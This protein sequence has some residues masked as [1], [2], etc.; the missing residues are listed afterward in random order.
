ME[1][2]GIQKLTLLDFP[3]KTA[4]T[5]FTGGCNM[6]CPFCHNAVLVTDINSDEVIKDE[7]I[8]KFLELRKGLLDGVCITGG[9]PLLH[10]GLFG[11]IKKVK[12]IGFLVKLDTNGTFP[13]RLAELISA[14]LVD[15]VAMDIK[16]CKEKYAKT[17]GISDFDITPVEK[18]INLLKNSGIDFEFRTTV[19]EEF[20][21]VE[22]IEKI[23]KHIGDSKYFLQ[24]FVDSGNTIC[25]DLHPV[26][27]EKIQN[28]QNAAKH[29]VKSVQ[30]RGI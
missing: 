24:Q 23:A 21:T 1:F 14:K 11:F 3:G 30:V 16:N 6:R 5:I 20:H 4:C 9:E 10:K 2:Y 22:D 7:E 25:S 29:F 19:V 18:S 17:V 13:D 15:Y 8:L 12:E 26:S 28:M 27:K